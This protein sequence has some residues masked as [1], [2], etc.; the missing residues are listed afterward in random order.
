MHNDEYDHDIQLSVEQTLFD[1]VQ[2]LTGDLMRLEKKYRRLQIRYQDKVWVIRKQ[3][4][5][6]QKLSGNKDSYLNE[7]ANKRRKGK[8]R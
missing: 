7:P 4:R 2:R 1:E 6:I 5:R 3:N 8:W